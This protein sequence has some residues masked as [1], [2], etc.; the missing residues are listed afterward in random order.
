M[1]NLFHSIIYSFDKHIFKITGMIAQE[2]IR[3]YKMDP[4]ESKR[5]KMKLKLNADN[6]KHILSTLDNAN[7]YIGKSNF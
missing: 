6:V 3:K 4:R 1:I 5:G 7:C 2:F